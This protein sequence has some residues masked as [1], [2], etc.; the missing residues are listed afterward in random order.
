MGSRTILRRRNGT[1]WKDPYIQLSIERI[2]RVGHS[3]VEIKPL[4]VETNVKNRRE[5]R[6]AI[7]WERTTRW[8]SEEM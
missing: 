3:L 1:M 2:K 7:S 8:N 6:K 4:S 5:D